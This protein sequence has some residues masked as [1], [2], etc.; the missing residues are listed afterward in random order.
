MYRIFTGVML[1]AV[2]SFAGCD[3]DLDEE[4]APPGNLE[5]NNSPPLNI[6]SKGL[7]DFDSSEVNFDNGGF[8]FDV[9]EESR[10]EK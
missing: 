3:I 4:P 5:L 6:P 2:C 9:G 7:E 8:D 10:G 1:T